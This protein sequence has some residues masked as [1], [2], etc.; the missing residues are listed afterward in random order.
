MVVL[1]LKESGF[2]RWVSSTFKS[3]AEIESKHSINYKY[4]TF[5]FI[6]YHTIGRAGYVRRG[7]FCVYMVIGLV[8]IFA[9]LS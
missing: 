3:I 9:L 7:Q 4:G 2:S 5:I 8:T 1:I 6:T